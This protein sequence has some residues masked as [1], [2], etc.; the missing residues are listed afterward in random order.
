MEIFDGAAE[1]L[2]DPAAR[3]EH[4]AGGFSWAEGPVWNFDAGYLT[5]SDVIGN[6][7]Y[8]YDAAG[9]VRTYR[10]PSDHTNGQAI[11]AGGSL[12]ACEH[13]TRRVTR[14]TPDGIET[15]V[16]CYEGKMFNSPNDVVA[17]RD[18]TLIFT[19]PAYGLDK[20]EEGGGGKRE[21]PFQGVY[22]VPPGSSEATLL[23]DD[24]AGPNGLALSPEENILYVV[25]SE[26]AHIRSFEVG[27]GWELS[28]GEVLVEVASEGAEVPDGMKVDL[29]GNIYCTGKGGVWVFSPEGETL[30]HISVPETT[31]NLAWG[32]DARILY[33]TADTGLYRIRCR[34]VGYALHRVGA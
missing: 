14:E 26:R 30:G 18:G 33:I 11:D 20:V 15:V 3:L 12:V 4:L 16:D 6:T 22:R 28:G 31:A 29:Q 23:A 19:D 9:G 8:R 2:V 32:G 34:A 17:A 13:R 5:F 1:R 21:L 7:M 27:A 25:D 24:F 10:S